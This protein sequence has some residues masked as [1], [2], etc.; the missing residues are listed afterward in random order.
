MHALKSA[1][2]LYFRILGKL[3]PGAAERHALALFSTPGTRREHRPGEIRNEV[4]TPFEVTVGRQRIMAWSYGVGR[5]VVL[6]HG[7]GGCAGD[8]T[9]LAAELIGAG[10][11]PVVF[12][13]PAHGLS[14]GKRT[15]L[16][17]AVDAIRAVAAAVAD[18]DSRSPIDALIGHSLGGA[19]AVLAMREGVPVSR[20][21]LLSPVAYPLAFID[22]FARALGLH[23]A[24]RQ[25][26]LDRIAMLAGGDLSRLDV[27]CAARELDMPGLVVHDR[28]DSRVD[29]TEGQAIANNWSGSSFVETA[30]LGHRGVLTSPEVHR[31]VTSFLRSGRTH[32]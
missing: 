18:R 7:W 20:L 5:P 29:P 22:V 25:G 19:A 10:Y 24:R 17:Q 30:G 15:N 26:M 11:R 16:I 12:D 4:A 23:E 31:R 28:S 14:A 2:P 21:V 8:W 13:L 27:A 9:P 3:A 1:L 32:D 6:V